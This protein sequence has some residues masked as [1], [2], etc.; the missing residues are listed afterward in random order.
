MD[1]AKRLTLLREQK[2]LT[3]DEMAKKLNI[4]RSALSLWEIGKREP[5][6]E[7]LKLLADFFGVSVDYLLGRDFPN[8]QRQ[9][10]LDLPMAAHYESNLPIDDDEELLEVIER[11][12]ERRRQKKGKNAQGKEK[13]ER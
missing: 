10:L 3:Q 13:G 7:T 5:N 4:S 9:K 6:F 1:F 2:G 12:L 11:M 8:D